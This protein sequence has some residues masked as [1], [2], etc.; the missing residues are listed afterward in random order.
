[1]RDLLVESLLTAA[2]G[3]VDY[4]KNLTADLS[5]EQMVAQPAAGA[6]HPAWVLSHLNAY[7]PV[8]AG[9]LQ[10]EVPTDPI[11]HEFG[12]RSKPVADVSAYASR[13]E[14]IAAFEAGHAAMR[15]ALE[16][17]TEERLLAPMPIE[18]WAKK[19]PHVG[20]MLPYVYARHEGMHLGQVSAWRRLQGLAS[21]KGG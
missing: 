17:V 16:A 14:L 21:V 1:M 4:A 5:A 8:I 15:A 2:G 7:H 11:E 20:S 19:F 12:M 13:D 6:N 10:G 9:L 3:N 18:R